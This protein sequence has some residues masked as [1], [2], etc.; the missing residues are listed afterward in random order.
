METGGRKNV[1]GYGKWVKFGSIYR[2]TESKQVLVDGVGDD[3]R[4][5]KLMEISIRYGEWMAKV[6]EM[7]YL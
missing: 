1:S 6:E 5:G 3:I 4:S 2:E 7:K